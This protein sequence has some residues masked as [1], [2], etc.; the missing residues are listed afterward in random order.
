VDP[1]V[2]CVRALTE[3]EVWAVPATVCVDFRHSLI[4]TLAADECDHVIVWRGAQVLRLD[5][6]GGLPRFDAVALGIVFRDGSNLEA[7]LEAVRILHDPAGGKSV[8][9][10]AG[11]QEELLALWAFDS[12]ASGISLRLMAN[13]LLGPG[14]WPGDGEHRK[15]LVRRL[16]AKGEALVRAGSAAVFSRLI[17]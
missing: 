16:L 17:S 11:L 8:G 15:S 4:R 9:S 6:V 3:E 1:R 5:V 2:L 14:D 13:N 10:S 7:Q 12:R